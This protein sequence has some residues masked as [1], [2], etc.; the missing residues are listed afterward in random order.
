MKVSSL[1]QYSSIAL[2]LAIFWALRKDIKQYIP[3]SVF[4]SWYAILID[5]VGGAFEWWHY[6]DNAF[7]FFPDIN[8]PLDYFVVP[9]L[10]M[11]FIKYV[12]RTVLGLF[13]GILAGS[14]LGGGIEYICLKYTKLIEFHNGYKLIYSFL[15]WSSLFLFS[16]SFHVWIRNEKFISNSGN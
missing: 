3:A 14:L 1:A 10:A 9:A 12:P 8:V 6:H 11:S 5:H 2:A 16:Y 4:A 15:L 13:L 7:S